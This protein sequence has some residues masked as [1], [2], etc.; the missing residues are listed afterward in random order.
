VTRDELIKYMAQIIRIH[1]TW[2]KHDYGTD[3]EHW[4]IVSS[5]LLTTMEMH[6]EIMIG[7]KSKYKPM[8]T[9]LTPEELADVIANDEDLKKSEE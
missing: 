5:E 8:P 4:E 3:Q 6:P 7:V 1:A 9:A 2:N